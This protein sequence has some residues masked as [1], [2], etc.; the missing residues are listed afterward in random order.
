MQLLGADL[1]SFQHRVYMAS[2]ALIDIAL[3][4]QRRGG[5]YRPR[6]MTL[7]EELLDLGVSEAVSLAA[8]NDLRITPGGYCAPRQTRATRMGRETGTGG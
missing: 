7:F 5:D 1:Q 6:G 2:P 4:L 8:S 3:R